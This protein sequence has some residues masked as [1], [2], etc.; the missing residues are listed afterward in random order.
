MPF[1]ARFTCG[2]GKN[3]LKE[4][5]E[6]TYSHNNLT[7]VPEEIICHE[8]SLEELYLDSNRI[9]ELPRVPYTFRLFF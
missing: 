9:N 8:R 1:F 7:Y 5:S 4:I 3:N 2:G 6:L